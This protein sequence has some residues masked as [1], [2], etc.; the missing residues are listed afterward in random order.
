MFRHFLPL[1]HWLVLLRPRSGW[2]C[3]ARSHRGVHDKRSRFR[4]LGIHGS[5]N[6][7]VSGQ[8][9]RVVPVPVHRPTMRG[10][11]VPTA[12]TMPAIQILSCSLDFGELI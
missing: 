3:D 1:H 6:T 4:S 10:L 12:A 7:V 2:F 8:V 9:R 11:V 5:V